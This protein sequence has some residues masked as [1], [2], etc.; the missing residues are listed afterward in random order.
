M[1]HLAILCSLMVAGSTPLFIVFGTGRSPTKATAYKN[2]T[3][4][5]AYTIT[6]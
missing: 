3:R 2:V 6:P 1:S 5:K 4:K